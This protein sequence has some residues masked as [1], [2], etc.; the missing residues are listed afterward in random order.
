MGFFFRCRAEGE[1]A[2]RGD[3]TFG[4]RWVRV[5]ELERVFLAAPDDFHWVTQGALKFYFKWRRTVAESA[6][7]A[8]GGS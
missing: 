1:L 8:R 7:V 3:G 2:S 5:E 4:H 6:L